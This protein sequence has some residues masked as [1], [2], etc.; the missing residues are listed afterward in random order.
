M[1]LINRNVVPYLRMFTGIMALFLVLF[2][3]H[4]IAISIGICL[5]VAYFL[6][7]KQH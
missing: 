7:P 1:K 3:I 6:M 5:G 4:W 2:G